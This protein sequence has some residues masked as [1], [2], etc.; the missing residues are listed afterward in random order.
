MKRVN[1]FLIILLIFGCAESLLLYRVFFSCREQGLPSRCGVKAS[2]CSG[3]SCC[4]ARALG[5]WASVVVHGLSCPMACGV[6]PNQGSNPCPLYWQVDSYTMNHQGSPCTFKSS[7][8]ACYFWK[9][10][11]QPREAYMCVCTHA[12]L[13]HGCHQEVLC[14]SCLQAAALGLLHYTG[15]GLRGT[16]TVFSE[17]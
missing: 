11:L 6:F 15:W 4:R 2:Q 9:L 14:L 12:A 17:F 5:A 16:R 7:R 13:L 1:F 8:N 3:F 10:Y